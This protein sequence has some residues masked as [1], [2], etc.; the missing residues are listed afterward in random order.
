M[1]CARPG[2]S[3]ARA[4]RGTPERLE[5]GARDGSG[6]SASTGPDEPLGRE[7][8]ALQTGRAQADRRRAPPRARPPRAFEGTGTRR[9]PDTEAIG[10]G[11]R[12]PPSMPRL[13]TTTARGGTGGEAGRDTI[14]PPNPANRSTLELLETRM[15]RI[16]KQIPGGRPKGRRG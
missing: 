13:W 11:H 10:P 8:V 1:R 4:P 7:R 6:S 12:K 15:T 9:G 16:P 2:A 14:A 3:P 5:A